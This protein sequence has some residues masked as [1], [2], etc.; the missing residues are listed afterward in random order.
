MKGRLVIFDIEIFALNA[1]RIHITFSLP[2]CVRVYLW[3]FILGQRAASV[4]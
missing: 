4:R 1:V 3:R 2:I